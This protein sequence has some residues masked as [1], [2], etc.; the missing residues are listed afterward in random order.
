MKYLITFIYIVVG[1][2]LLFTCFDPKFFGYTIQY[3][4]S[5]S[6]FYLILLGIIVISI[7]RILNKKVDNDRTNVFL[8]LAIFVSYCFLTLYVGKYIERHNAS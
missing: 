6:I 1:K 3:Y 2:I 8:S 7:K 5:I 4:F